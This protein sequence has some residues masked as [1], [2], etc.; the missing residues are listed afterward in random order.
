MEYTLTVTERK[1]VGTKACRA[2]REEGKI[3]AVVYSEGKNAQM[4][5]LEVRD[6]ERVWKSAGE[7]TI[8]TLQ[9]VGK[10]KAVL[11]Q[12]VAVDSLYDTPLHADFYVVQ[13]DKLV[14]VDVPL[15]FEGIAPAVKELGG[16]LAK[17]M[18]ELT[19]EALPK[20]LPKEIIVDISVLKT[21]DDQIQVKDIVLPSG[22]TATEDADEVVAL[23]QEAREEEEYVTTEDTADIVGAVEVEKKGK[24]EEVKESEE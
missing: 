9:G 18:Y 14:E 6:F 4:I 2:L 24:E 22:V 15:V 8:V 7:S 16:N 10:D 13:T 12:D 19:I 11:I 5:T 3:P 17:I 20:D 1:E 21:F 23:V